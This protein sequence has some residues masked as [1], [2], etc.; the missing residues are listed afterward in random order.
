MLRILI[1]ILLLP[2]ILFHLSCVVSGQ[3]SITDYDGNEYKTVIIGEQL[4]MAENLKSIH[5]AHGEKIKRVCYQLIRENCDEFGGLYAWD[6]LKVEEKN[7]S[8]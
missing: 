2:F 4:W 8:F 3:E 1:L 5:T 6:E 7:E